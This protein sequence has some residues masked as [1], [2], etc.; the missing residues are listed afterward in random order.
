M[1]SPTPPL[2]DGAVLTCTFN[3]HSLTAVGTNIQVKDVAAY[4][5]ARPLLEERVARLRK[6]FKLGRDQNQGQGGKKGRKKA[7][8]GEGDGGVGAAH[9]QEEEEG[10]DLE[11]A[12]ISRVAAKHVL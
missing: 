9:E 7:N 5:D 6:V 4:F 2:P 10:E 3:G 11:H 8:K 12:I 1:A